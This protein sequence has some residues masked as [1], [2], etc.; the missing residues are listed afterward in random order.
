MKKKKGRRL[1]RKKRL[2]FVSEKKVGVCFGKKGRRLF[3]KKKVGVLQKKRKVF[4]LQRFFFL[5]KK[6]FLKKI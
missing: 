3:S 2:A 4:F 1:F 6:K 5:K